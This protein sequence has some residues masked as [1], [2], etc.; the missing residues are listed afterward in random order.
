MQKHQPFE[1]KQKVK[2]TTIDDQFEKSLNEVVEII[3]SEEKKSY[4][5][6]YVPYEQYAQK[7]SIELQTTAQSFYESIVNGFRVLMENAR[8]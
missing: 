7:R 2:L 6:A 3:L 5:N 8:N 4:Q 1:K